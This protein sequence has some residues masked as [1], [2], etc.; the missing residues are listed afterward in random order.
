MP[1]IMETI[2]A[3]P[4]LKIL[5][6]ALDIVGGV[7]DRLESSGTLTFFAPNDDAFGRL[8][9]DQVLGDTAKLSDILNYHLVGDKHYKKEMDVVN[10]DSLVTELG[11][12]LSIYLDENEIMIDNAHLV[13]TDIECSNGVIHI[14]DN[15]F[16][17]QHSGWYETLA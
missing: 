5:K 11:K 1:T 12:S 2:A 17:P 6:K 10:L 9:V 16:L 14:I 13:T 7:R 3:E 4:S 15:V 8:N